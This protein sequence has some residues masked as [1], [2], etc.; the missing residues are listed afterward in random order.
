MNNSLLQER[1]E[2]LFEELCLF[3]ETLPIIVEGKKDELA[4]RKI[5]ANGEII[6]LNTGQSILNFC[7]ELSRKY[8]EVIIL[9]DWDS[10]GAQL[11]TKLIQ[12]FKFNSVKTVKKFWRDFKRFCSKEVREVEYLTKFL[13]T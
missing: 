7:E 12:N 13:P 5:G 4:L 8:S 1:I 2:E 9:T 6:K 3:N 10:K 11:F